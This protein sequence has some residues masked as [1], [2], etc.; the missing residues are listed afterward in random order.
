MA[1]KVSIRISSEIKNIGKVASR[2]LKELKPHG[3]DEGIAF[4]IRLC[5][6]EAV[7]NAIVHGNKSQRHLKVTITYSIHPDRV[8]VEV[9]DEGNG[10]DHSNLSDPTTE[11]NIMRNSGRGVLII[12][13]L[14]DRVEFRDQG[15]VVKMVKYIK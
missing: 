1:D 7:R 8:E 10:F 11:D 13:K 6:D 9:A 12:K 14:M 2:I 3:L 15:N 5:I 4:D